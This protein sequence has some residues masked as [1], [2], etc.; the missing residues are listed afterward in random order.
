MQLKPVLQ[1]LPAKSLEAYSQAR[2]VAL[3]ILADILHSQGKIA[4]C[5]FS[6]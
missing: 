3:P 5:L 4:Q 2:R 6:G 1:I